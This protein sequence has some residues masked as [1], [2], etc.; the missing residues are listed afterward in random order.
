MKELFYTQEVL[1]HQQLVLRHKRMQF[2]FCTAA[3]LVLT[4][5]VCLL[6]TRGNEGLCTLVN[7]FGSGAYFCWLLYFC[8]YAY[9]KEKARERLIKE[10]LTGRRTLVTGVITDFE[11]E[12][13]GLETEYLLYL[14]PEDSSQKRRM[15]RLSGRCGADPQHLT[16]VK[17]VLDVYGDRVVGIEVAA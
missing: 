12:N 17:L 13:T 5:A 16:G 3:W 7:G 10:I 9:K 14:M 2:L 11:T 8:T 1:E 6:L 4:V 15:Y